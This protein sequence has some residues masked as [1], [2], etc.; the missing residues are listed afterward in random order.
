MSYY[1]KLQYYY[2]YFSI[3]NRNNGYWL[4][5]N[6]CKDL[7]L[8]KFKKDLLEEL[9]KYNPRD[10]QKLRWKVNFEMV[11]DYTYDS[12]SGV[13]K[14]EG[15]RIHPSVSAKINKDQSIEYSV[16]GGRIYTHT[17]HET[18]PCKEIFLHSITNGKK[19]E[20]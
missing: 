15:T 12:E 5:C 19:W 9:P 2:Q 20:R 1:T 7:D 3:N 14:L 16:F 6:E 11:D 4:Y 18:Y 8:K 13:K 10:G 17:Y